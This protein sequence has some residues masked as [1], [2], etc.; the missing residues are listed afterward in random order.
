MNTIRS[1]TCVYCD[2]EGMRQSNGESSPWKFDFCH[3][4]TAT[5]SGTVLE[6]CM[7][8]K[9]LWQAATGELHS[10]GTVQDD[11]TLISQ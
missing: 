1:S 9:M 4:T 11:V 7:R 8:S 3:S 10:T 2:Y 6:Y 5:S